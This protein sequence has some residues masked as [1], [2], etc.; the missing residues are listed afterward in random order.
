MDKRITILKDVIRHPVTAFR[1]IDKNGREYLTGAVFLL[2]TVPF[3]SWVF[4]PE[5]FT[6]SGAIAG[7]VNV[8]VCIVLTYYIGRFLKGKA[9]FTGLFSALGYSHLP[10]VFSSI[11]FGIGGRLNMGTIRQIIDLFQDFQEQVATEE[12]A[13]QVATQMLPLFKE[14]FTPINISLGVIAF[15]IGIWGVILTILACREAHKFSTKRA[16][17]TFVIAM[18]VGGMI[19]SLLV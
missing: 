12:V 6:V 1:E 11:I 18:F 19:N 14:L 9:E 17:G 15:L 13:E 2:L 16:V 3:L 10:S 8:M 5:F 4:L 7:L